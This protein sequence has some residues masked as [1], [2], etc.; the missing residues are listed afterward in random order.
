MNT[1][2]KV[3]E[4]IIP[5]PY[6][7]AAL[8]RVQELRQWREQIPR[9]AVPPTAD[10]TQK[11]SNAASV[12]PAF[13][14]LTNMA[15]A[16]QPSLARPDAIPP[17]QLRDLTAWAE[18]YGPL[19]DELEAIA[20]FIRYSVKV[21]LNTAGSE[22]LATYWIAQR[23]AKLPATAHLKPYVADMRRALGRVRKTSP[24]EAAQKAAERAA[25]AAEKVARKKPV[26]K[27]L[28]APTTEK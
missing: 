16:S 26:V 20:Q 24:E 10:A 5:N 25:K 7:D 22:A 4:S 19:A 17:A 18:A 1:K 3:V 13:V 8:V 9:L 11:L 15:T 2:E 6:A 28:P 12:P 14:E 23:L 27:A 21:A